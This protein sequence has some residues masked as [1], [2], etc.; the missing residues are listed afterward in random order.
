MG[1]AFFL[2]CFRAKIRQKELD[3]RIAVLVGHRRTH[4]S[5]LL[6]AEQELQA[7]KEQKHAA[8]DSLK[9]LLAAGDE[10]S[11]FL[12]A[13][14]SADLAKRSA[15]IEIMGKVVLEKRSARIEILERYRDDFKNRVSEVEEKLKVENVQREKQ[16]EL[17]L[18]LQGRYDGRYAYIMEL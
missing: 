7:E 10:F 9:A 12:D 6:A 13:S 1:E 4:E 14:F 17:M 15:R 16:V 3:A 5:A 18:Q 11:K 2:D 8:E